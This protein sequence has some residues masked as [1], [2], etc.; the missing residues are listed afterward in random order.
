MEWESASWS[1]PSEISF[2]LDWD[3]LA[4]FCYIDKCPQPGDGRLM[5]RWLSYGRDRSAAGAGAAA[6]VGKFGLDRSCS[7][8]VFVA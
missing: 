1:R 7:K 4:R 8:L 2:A 3:L 5:A 6:L